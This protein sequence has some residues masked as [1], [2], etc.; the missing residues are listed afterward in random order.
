MEIIVADQEKDEH[1]CCTPTPL[2]STKS[3]SN[4]DDSHLYWVNLLGVEAK[5]TGG[6]MKNS[7]A[8]PENLAL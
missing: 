1:L 3:G 6:T 8:A 5:M 7:C 4:T 2:P